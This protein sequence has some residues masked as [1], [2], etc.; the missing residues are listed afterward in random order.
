MAEQETQGVEDEHAAFDDDEDDVDRTDGQMEEGRDVKG[1]AARGAVIGAATGGA[2]GA[3]IGA[4]LV[5]RPEVVRSAKEAFEGSG[6]HVVRAVAAALSEVL[7]SRSV[8][9]LLSGSG[10]G[11]RTEA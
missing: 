8:R 5:S 7:T 11:D 4:L 1:W 9:Q 2:A 10:N 6:K 3:G